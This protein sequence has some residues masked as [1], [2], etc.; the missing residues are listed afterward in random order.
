MDIDYEVMKSVSVMV[1]G[2]PLKNIGCAAI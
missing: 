2:V 1:F